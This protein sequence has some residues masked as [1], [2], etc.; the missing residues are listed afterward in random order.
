MANNVK[1]V[2]NAD[3]ADKESR[4]A[5]DN[6]EGDEEELGP[7]KPKTTGEPPDNL[8]RRA[9]WFKKRHSGD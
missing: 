6:S 8:Q 4:P 2:K 1:D 3:K 7:V 5:K 9:D